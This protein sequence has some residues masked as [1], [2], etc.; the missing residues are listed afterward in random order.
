MYIKKVKSSLGKMIIPAPYKEGL[1]DQYQGRELFEVLSK[2]A[3]FGNYGAVW[4]YI[5]DFC[6]EHRRYEYIPDKSYH[7]DLRA[8]YKVGRHP[9]FSILSALLKSKQTVREIEGFMAGIWNPGVSPLLRVLKKAKN[10][11][12]FCDLMK[13]YLRLTL[14]IGR[15]RFRVVPSFQKKF[16]EKSFTLKD[17]LREENQ[18]LRRLILRRGVTIKEVLGKMKL[19]AKDKEGKIYERFDKRAGWNDRRSRYLYVVCPSTG[20]EYLLGIPARFDSPKVARR[21][22][23]NLPEDAGFAKEA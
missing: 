13:P 21:W 10:E 3:C 1:Y 17:F 8:W 18:E 7:E 5:S 23:F 16:D 19:I 15:R 22:T 20:Q 11:K 6:E 9:R 2:N 14:R 4:C 12:D